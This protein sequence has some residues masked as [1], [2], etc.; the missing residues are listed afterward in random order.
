MEANG[1]A[2]AEVLHTYE[3]PRGPSLY[4]QQPMTPVTPYE[5]SATAFQRSG[6]SL[7]PSVSLQHSL[8]E[9]SLTTS[10]HS[11]LSSSATFQCSNSPSHITTLRRVGGSLDNMLFSGSTTANYVESNSLTQASAYEEPQVAV[12]QYESVVNSQVRL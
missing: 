8:R 12:S 4:N 1:Y 5:P 11:A 2:Y 3:T 6:T 7:G 9:I 10:H